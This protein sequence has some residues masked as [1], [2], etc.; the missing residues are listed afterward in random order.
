MS[1][2]LVWVLGD[3][4][5]IEQNQNPVQNLEHNQSVK[6]NIPSTSQAQPSLKLS[7]GQSALPLSSTS[8]NEGASSGTAKSSS[9]TTGGA[10]S[11]SVEPA[12]EYMDKDA[13]QDSEVNLYLREPGL[14]RDSTDFRVPQTLAVAY[15][16]GVVRNASEAVCAVLHVLMCESGYCPGDSVRNLFTFVFYTVILHACLT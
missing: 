8:H 2:D 12:D 1:G 14:V 5:P 4:V 10:S 6:N 15:Q 11:V 3:S 13:I 16:S 7:S 9:D